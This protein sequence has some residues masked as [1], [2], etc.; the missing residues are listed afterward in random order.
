MVDLFI[1]DFIQVHW[2]LFW[3]ETKVIHVSVLK[4]CSCLQTVVFM[5]EQVKILSELALAQNNMNGLSER[6]RISNYF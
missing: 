6:L 3:C 2:G 5:T 4:K 1:L